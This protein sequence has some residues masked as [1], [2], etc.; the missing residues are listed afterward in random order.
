MIEKN[1]TPEALQDL[2]KQARYH[3]GRSLYLGGIDYD[4]AVSELDKA[5]RMDP[6][7]VAAL[8]HLGQAIRLQ[9][10]RST[11]KR[12]EDALRAY[13]LKGAP[14]GDEERVR[15][16]LGSRAKTGLI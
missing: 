4:R 8:Y 11:L 14:L 7:N 1:Y 12:A 3:L 15:E 6:D 5:T 10:E 2:L 16:F 13:L 9:V